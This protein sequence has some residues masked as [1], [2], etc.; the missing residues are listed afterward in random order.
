MG[1]LLLMS[2]FVLQ[3]P[4]PLSSKSLLRLRLVKPLLAVQAARRDLLEHRPFATHLLVPRWIVRDLLGAGRL[5]SDP[6]V[7]DLTVFDLIACPRLDYP[8]LE[9]LPFGPLL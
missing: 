5:V 6:I 4:P 2:L 9:K 3:G 8:Q 7:S 1:S